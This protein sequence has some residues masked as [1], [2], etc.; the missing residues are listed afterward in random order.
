MKIKLI[1][2]ALLLCA[3]TVLASCSFVNPDGDPD[4][5][6]KGV[7]TG[8]DETGETGE[9]TTPDYLKN[10]MK[11][12]A[13]APYKG[14]EI[15][16]DEEEIEHTVEHQIEELLSENKT[17]TEIDGPSA[18]GHVLTVSFEGFVEGERSENACAENQTI[19]LGAG[20]FIPGFEEGMY[21]L[22]KDETATLDLTFPEEYYEDM[23]GKAVRF[24]I[25]VHKIEANTTVYNDELIAKVTHYATVAEYEAKLREDARFNYILSTCWNELMETSIFMDLPEEPIKEYY[26]EVVE[27]YT[28]YAS[29]MSVDLATVTKTYLGMEEEDFYKAVQEEAE[30]SLKSEIMLEAILQKEGIELTPALYEER[31]QTYLTN[32]EYQTIDDME[33][34]YGKDVL[35]ASIRR[36][37]VYELIVDNVVEK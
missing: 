4:A 11:H 32:F 14:M 28:S 35:E 36:D 7:E 20:G 21:G 15:T 25:T 16:V 10:P 37:I 33:A 17:M 31:M 6:D 12:V 22:M 8:A 9:K 24:E 13:L 1:V 30:N 27:Y 3:A 5:T 34:D 29:M 2:L 23:A 18:E 26:D 19:T